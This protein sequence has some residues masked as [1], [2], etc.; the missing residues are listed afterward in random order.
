MPD[1][2][3]STGGPHSP[4][5][6]PAVTPL[7]PRYDIC[8]LDPTCLTCMTRRSP[9]HP[10]RRS[11]NMTSTPVRHAGVITSPKKNCIILVFFFLSFFFI[12]FFISSQETFP[13]FLDGEKERDRARERRKETRQ[14]ARE[15]HRGNDAII[16]CCCLITLQQTHIPTRER[17]WKS[18][19]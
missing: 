14:D 16:C 6:S 18:R 17:K 19:H 8:Q 12:F 15:L 2:G 4:S 7:R 5:P 11:V 9:G 13:I 1:S 10:P 3:P